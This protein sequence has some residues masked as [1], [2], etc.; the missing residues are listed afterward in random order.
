M[1]DYSISFARSARKELE[2]LPSPLIQRIFK[3]IEGLARNPR[4]A[5]SKKLQGSRDLY[6]IRVGDYRVVYSIFDREVRI[7]I[8]TIRH[9][10]KAYD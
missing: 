4:P 2:V 8:V 3:K 1:A 5:R 10:S 9:R 6:R 7:E